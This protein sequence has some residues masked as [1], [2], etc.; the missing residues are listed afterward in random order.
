MRCLVATRY[1]PSVHPA[2]H[3]FVMDAFEDA[4][5]RLLLP[6]ITR[7]VRSKF[8]SLAHDLSLGVFSDNLRRLLMS[9]PLRCAPLP[10]AGAAAAAAPDRVF[11]PTHLNETS[12]PD[13]VSAA[14]GSPGDRLPVVGLDPGWRHGCKWAACD[15]LGTVLQAGVLHITSTS[16]DCPDSEMQL[17]TRTMKSHGI[18]TIGL[19]NGQACR[20]TEKWLAQAVANGLF[21]PLRVRYT[22]VSE[23][24]ASVYSASPLADR[25]LPTL[26]VSLRGA[27][28]IAR[29]LQD[30]LAELVKIEPQH[31]GVGMYQHDLPPKRLEEAVNELME[32]CISFV[33]VD[34]NTAQQHV[35]ARVAGLS[36]SKARAIIAYRSTNGRIRCRQE[37]LKI[38]GI[39]RS[40]FSQCAGFLRVRPNYSNVPMDSSKD[41]EFISLCSDDDVEME[42]VS[43]K[44]R[45]RLVSGIPA[46]P[47]KRKRGK[48]ADSGELSF[49]PLDQTAIHPDSYDLATSLIRYLRYEISDVGCPALRNAA[50]VLYNSPNH[51][52]ADRL[53]HY[54]VLS[55]SPPDENIVQQLPAPRSRVYPRDLMPHRK[56]ENGVGPQETVFCTGSLKTAI[57][58]ATATETMWTQHSVSGSVVCPD[59]GVEIAKDDQLIR[60]RHS[61]QEGVQ[62]LIVTHPWGWGVGAEDGGEIVSPTRQAEA[63]QVI[64]GDCTLAQFQT[65]AFGIETTRDI[66]EA[67]CRPLDFDERQGKSVTQVDL[68]NLPRASELGY[69]WLTTA[70]KPEMNITVSLVFAGNIR[71]PLDDCWRGSRRHRNSSC[72]LFSDQFGPLFRSSITSMMDLRPGLQVTGRVENV[73]TFGAFVDIGLE[74]SAFLPLSAFPRTNRA[75]ASAQCLSSSF[76]GKTDITHMTLHLGDRVKATVSSIDVKWGRVALAQVSLLQ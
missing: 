71:L 3:K 42:V 33:G 56:A 52:E 23:C 34:V 20:Q 7:K 69:G 55:I 54:R 58:I 18:N 44:R 28:S 6:H 40:T 29:R 19:G 11:S 68:V 65:S 35:L 2:H 66:L 41:V 26:D 50:Q 64:M 27:V 36:D 37:L 17:F 53:G 75:S 59:V 60:L 72:Y 15:P 70:N 46:R 74:E 48:E 67:L 73:T 43:G 57:V 8:T 30:P 5:K 63:H 25:E 32:E 47:V 24:G 16:G 76:A 45:L 49:N 1:L 38:K 31:L 9:A 21:A 39:G 62:V 51:D 13:V 4:W 61:R 14:L 12:S 22:I 10:P